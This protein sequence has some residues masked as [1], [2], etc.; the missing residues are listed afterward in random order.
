MPRL[1][2]HQRRVARTLTPVVSFVVMRSLI[3]PGVYASVGLDPA[4]AR[5]A[6][7]ANPHHRATIAWSARKLMPFLQEIGVVGGP[8]TR[9][10]RCANL[11]DRTD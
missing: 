8:L 11:I 2:A 10:W 4:V 7:L 6:A 9:L 3:H 5:R 1:T